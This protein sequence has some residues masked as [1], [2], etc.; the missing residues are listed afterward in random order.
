[1]I[2][3]TPIVQPVLEIVGTVA[4][5][6]IAAYVPMALAAFQKRTGIVLTANQQAA[7]QAAAQ[8]AA[9]R[10][11]TLID[12]KA[13]SV[14]HVSVG[15]PTIQAEAQAVIGYLPEAA[16]ALGVTPDSVAAMIVGKVNTAPAAAA[17]SGTAPG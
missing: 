6:V 2:D 5:A 3:L 1:V 16:A 10:I 7:V 9:G 15:S 12:Q 13:L 8:N 14:A 4:A 17:A 11:E